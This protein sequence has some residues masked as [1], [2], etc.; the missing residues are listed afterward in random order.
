MNKC[1]STNDFVYVYECVCV[2]IIHGFFSH[3]KVLKNNLS[4]S[5]LFTYSNLLKLQ[6][7]VGSEVDIQKAGNLYAFLSFEI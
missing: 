7:K 2:P 4:L 3:N 1:A 6:Q 5:F